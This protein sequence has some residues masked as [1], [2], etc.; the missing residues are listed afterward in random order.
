MWITEN[1]TLYVIQWEIDVNL[2]RN[3]GNALQITKAEQYNKNTTQSLHETVLCFPYVLF[4]LPHRLKHSVY[5]EGCEK[6]S[7]PRS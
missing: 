3:K 6:I 7:F 2:G 5:E 4:F 1:A